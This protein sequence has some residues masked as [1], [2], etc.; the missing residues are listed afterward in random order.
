MIKLTVRFKV[1][2]AVNFK[3]TG[4]W[5]VVPRS[6]E[7][8]AY[9]WYQSSLILMASVCTKFSVC[10]IINLKLLSDNTVILTATRNVFACFNKRGSKQHNKNK[11]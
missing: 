2:T 6:L 8:V 10:K 1:L 5:V 4:F 7:L 11:Q 3:I 9:S